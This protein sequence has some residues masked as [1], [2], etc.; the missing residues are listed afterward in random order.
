MSYEP[1][2]AIFSPSLPSYAKNTSNPSNFNSISSSLEIL[3]SSSIT[4]IFSLIIIST[5]V[6]IFFFLLYFLK[7]STLIQQFP[8]QANFKILT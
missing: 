5:S 6:P 2:L 3:G 1:Y 8:Q 4:N 7:F